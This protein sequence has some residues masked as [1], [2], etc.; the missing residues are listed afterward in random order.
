MRQSRR[1]RR[2]HIGSSTPE[3]KRSITQKKTNM[4]A[5]KASHRIIGG[6]CSVGGRGGGEGSGGHGEGGGGGSGSIGDGNVGAGSVG[7]GDGVGTGGGGI[8]VKGQQV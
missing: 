5:I 8:C 4:P 7:N 6:M 3:Y 1:S 2:I